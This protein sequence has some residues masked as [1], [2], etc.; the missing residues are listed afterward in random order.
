MLRADQSLLWLGAGVFFM[1]AGA[2][3]SHISNQTRVYALAPHP[4]SRI[5]SIYMVSSFVGAAAGSAL[6]ALA[7]ARWHWTGVCP[8]GFAMSVLAFGILLIWPE[9]LER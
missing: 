1:D 4:R 5:T 7:W 6:G 9:K 3:G 8:L 2:Q